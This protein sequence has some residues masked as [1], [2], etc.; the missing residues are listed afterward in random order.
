M[1]GASAD[2]DIAPENEEFVPPPRRVERLAPQVAELSQD[3]SLV[4][5]L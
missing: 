5:K 2:I 4:E 1:I 3:S